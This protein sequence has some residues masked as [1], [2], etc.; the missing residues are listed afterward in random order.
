M[1][2]TEDPGYIRH[3]VDPGVVRY[4]GYLSRIRN[5]GNLYYILGTLEIQ[6]TLE[7]IET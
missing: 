5:P 7:T 1:R 4:N 6:V 3:I 2:Y